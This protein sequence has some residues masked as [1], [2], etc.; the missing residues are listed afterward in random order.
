M[1]LWD[2][3]ERVNL[4]HTGEKPSTMEQSVVQTNAPL[5]EILLYQ[6]VFFFY[7]GFAL[8]FS[9]FYFFHLY[10]TPQT[11]SIRSP[12]LAAVS[13]A[14]SAGCVPPPRHCRP[15]LIAPNGLS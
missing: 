8:F 1:S 14:R 10:P 12:Q 11:V 4:C 6:G 5:M 3:G 9:L 2:G 7:P 15:P 13:L